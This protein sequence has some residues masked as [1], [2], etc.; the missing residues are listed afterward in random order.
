MNTDEAFLEAMQVGSYFAGLAIENSML[1]AAHACANPLTK[2]Y[3]ITHGPALAVLLPHVVRWNACPE[4][5]EFHP[6]LASYVRELANS[7]GLPST[8]RELGVPKDHL[9]RLSQ[10]AHEQWTGRFNP[11]PIVAQEIYEC[12]W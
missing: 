7:A 1:G 6:D 12:A 3:G 10:E 2:N 9:P 5:A 11:R 8:L 4:Y